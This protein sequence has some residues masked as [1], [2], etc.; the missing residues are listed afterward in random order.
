MAQNAMVLAFGVWL[1]GKLLVVR[2]EV[3][4]FVG[5][6]SDPIPRQSVPQRSFHYENEMHRRLSTLMLTERIFLNSDLT[7]ATFVKRMG[8]S[9]RTVRTLINHE[10]GYDHFRTF[11]NHYRIAEARRLLADPNCTD[12][13]VTIA[14][15]SG[16]ASLASFNRAFRAIEGCTPSD[17]RS[18]VRECSPRG[19]AVAE[20]EI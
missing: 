19:A 14:L 4:A 11:L 7:F 10:L 17:Y 1:A 8:A 6:E 16:F 9:E 12:K 3:L 15:D 5:G 2:P 20:A 13:L 18:A